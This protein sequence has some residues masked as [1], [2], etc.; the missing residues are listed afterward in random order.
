VVVV[1][2]S[3]VTVTLVA[4][5]APP[6][7]AVAALVRM[8]LIPALAPLVRKVHPASDLTAIWVHPRAKRTNAVI[9]TITLILM[10]VD[11]TPTRS[12]SPK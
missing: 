8:V 10:K 2:V 4:S 12:L 1:V 5:A 3:I 9:S 6:M 7:V 11:R